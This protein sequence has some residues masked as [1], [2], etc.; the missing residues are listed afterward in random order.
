MMTK[1]LE[2]YMVSKEITVNV[3]QFKAGCLEYLRK[4]ESGKL[5]AVTV[6]RRGK[7]V[8]VVERAAVGKAPIEDAYGFMR[9]VMQLSPAYDPFEQV[10]DEP[11]DPFLTKG[12]GDDAAA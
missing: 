3:T 8:A 10:V 12:S 4:L 6:A 1:N 5:T 2:V 9:D 11:S 7:P